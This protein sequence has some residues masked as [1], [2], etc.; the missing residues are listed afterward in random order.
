MTNKP[1]LGVIKFASCDGCQLALLDAE[2][3]LLAIAAEVEIA[4]FLEASSRFEPG[5]YDVALVE[6]SVTV[7]APRSRFIPG[8]AADLKPGFTL[9]SEQAGANWN[10]A[11]IDVSAATSW[12][13]GRL[14][15]DDRPLADAAAE[16]NRYSKRKVVVDP[17]I[18]A[19]QIVGVFP[20]GDVEAFTR[21]AEATQIA[22]ITYSDENR[23]E[24]TSPA[25][26]SRPPD[27]PYDAAAPSS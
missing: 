18:A 1:R 16:M 13:T 24:L 20:A 19:T 26:K 15:F 12:R 2:D 17:A 8:K 25:K 7:E 21:A 10:V 22:A 4:Y 6:G 14:T 5:P 27:V 3:E 9:K 11:K 23:I